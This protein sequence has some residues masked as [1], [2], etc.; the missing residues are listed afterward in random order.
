LDMIGGMRDI[1]GGG[2]TGGVTTVSG[3]S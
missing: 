1:G 3:R 2:W